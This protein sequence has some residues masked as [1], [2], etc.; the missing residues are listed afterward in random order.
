[1]NEIDAIIQ[2]VTALVADYLYAGVFLASLIETV[3]PP[4]PTLAIFPLAGYVASQNNFQLFQTIML[5][6]SGGAGASIGSLVFYFAARKLGRIALL[7]YLKHARISEEKLEKV[8]NWFAKHGDKA[9][10]FGR[11]LPLLREIISIPAGLL[12]M[13][14]SKFL[15][16]TFLGSCVYS[17]GLILAGYY[18]GKAAVE[19]FQ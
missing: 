18:F 19:F 12:K 11:L 5:G 6:I 17:I 1:M 13:N 10:F 8:E 9:V 4:I 16:Y 2:W 14:I 3:F 15:L 7:K